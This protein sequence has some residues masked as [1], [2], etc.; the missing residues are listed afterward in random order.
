MEMI[1]AETSTEHLSA[2]VC[3]NGFAPGNLIPSGRSFM[4]YNGVVIW[5]WS[6]LI[7]TLGEYGKAVAQAFSYVTGSRIAIQAISVLLL[8]ALATVPGLAHVT[9]IEIYRKRRTQV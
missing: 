9:N 6:W 4:G 2:H 3:T 1:P 8:E 5:I 7:I